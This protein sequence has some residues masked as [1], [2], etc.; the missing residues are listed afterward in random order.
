ML[1]CTI[2]HILEFLF[3]IL[4]LGKELFQHLKFVWLMLDTWL[5]CLTIQNVQLVL[6]RHFHQ[7][8]LLSLEKQFTF[9]LSNIL[10][11]IF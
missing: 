7:S 5:E 9:C 4:K 11:F 8:S 1:Y 10:A 3:F 6:Q 2:I